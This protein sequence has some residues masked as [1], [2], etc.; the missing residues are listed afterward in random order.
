MPQKNT[1]NEVIAVIGNVDEKRDHM[2]H[3]CCYQCVRKVSLYMSNDS[4]RSY[5]VAVY[6][7]GQG[8]I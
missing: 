8:R 6:R 7:R 4:P 2:E 1:G 5:Y 3:K